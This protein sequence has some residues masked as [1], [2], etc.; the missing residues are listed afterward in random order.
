MTPRPRNW[1]KRPQMCLKQEGMKIH[2]Q[3]CTKATRYYP[4]PKEYWSYW[5][6]W[7]CSHTPYPHPYPENLTINEVNFCYVSDPLLWNGNC[8]MA[9]FTIQLPVLRKDD[10]KNPLGYTLVWCWDDRCR[11]DDNFQFPTVLD[12]GDIHSPSSCLLICQKSYR[13][14]ASI[15]TGN[16]S[17]SY[18]QRSELLVI[19]TQMQW[20]CSGFLHLS[21]I[22][23]YLTVSP[24]EFSRK[25]FRP[26]GD[27]LLVFVLILKATIEAKEVFSNKPVSATNR[28]FKK[29][30]V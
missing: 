29:L 24:Q 18:A 1:T 13:L 30:G 2:E 12:I 25:R 4:I 15:K 16:G 10:C 6:W 19:L 20:K 23:A 28:N 8:T 7:L 11:K 3:V 21:G 27:L 9:S 14:W 5:F 26:H 17:S 22:I